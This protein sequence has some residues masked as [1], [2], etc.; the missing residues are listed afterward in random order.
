MEQLMERAQAKRTD[1]N[2]KHPVIRK[3]PSKIKWP[4]GRTDIAARQEKLDWLPLQTSENELK[5]PA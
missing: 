5:R 2:P 4:G 3:G 1:P